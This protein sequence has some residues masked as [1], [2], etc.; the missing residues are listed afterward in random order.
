[1]FLASE[2][3]A[4]FTTMNKR[5]SIRYGSGPIELFPISISHKQASACITTTNHYMDILWNSTPF[6]W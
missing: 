4:S 6:V 2:K 3:L 1:M 5:V